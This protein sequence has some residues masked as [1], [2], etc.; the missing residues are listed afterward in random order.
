MIRAIS[1]LS[2]FLACA[3]GCTAPI[4]SP[5][6]GV[7]YN[8]AAQAPDYLRNPVIVIPGILGSKLK[9]EETDRV[10]WGAFDGTYANPETPDGARLVA[11]PM[12]F[13]SP[14]IE[15]RDEVFSNGSLDRVR[16]RLFGIPVALRAYAQILA[17][18]GVGGYRDEPLGMAGAIDYGD[19]H[20][21][22]FQFDYDWRRDNVENARRLHRFILEKRE[23]V[24]AELKRRYGVDKPDLQFDI[25]AHSMGGLL[26]RYYLRYGDADL[27]EEG[28]PTVTWAGASLLDRLILVGTPNAGSVNALFQLVNGTRMAPILPRYSAAVLGTMPSVYQLLP[29]PR[30]GA[31]LDSADATRKLN[32]YDPALWTRMGWGLADP[33]AD[34]TLRVL[35]PDVA[36]PQERRRI[37]L[38]HQQ[39]CLQRAERFARALDAPAVPPQGVSISLFAGDAIQMEAVAA[40]DTATGKLR[41]IRFSPGDGTVLRSSAVMDER[42]DGDWTRVLRTP[43]HFSRVTF[44]FTDHL[45][46]TRDPAFT[47]NVLFLLLEQSR[48]SA[49]VM[50]AP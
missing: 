6:I 33:N 36:D 24:R 50:Q 22:C 27:P 3:S 21:T 5:N 26:A 19:E 39:K 29:R 17:T 7:L 16:L 32:L 41:V 28:K 31:L 40:A 12:R 25:V 30:H 9:D 13:G 14:L 8:R 49:N 42:L 10:V 46:M 20:F 4:P 35:L 38:D 15:L 1:I 23:Y 45:G 48:S 2:F 43:I 44:L 34:P 18:L 47:D 37:A 11:I